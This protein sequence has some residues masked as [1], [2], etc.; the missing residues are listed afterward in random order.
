MADVRTDICEC[1]SKLD[2][3]ISSTM[4]KEQRVCKHCGKIHYV[5]DTP[6]DWER[7]KESMRTKQ[8]TCDV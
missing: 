3:Q 4:T 6:I 2:F 1:G 7:L 8:E 5:E